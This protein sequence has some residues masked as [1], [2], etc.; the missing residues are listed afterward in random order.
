MSR[1]DKLSSRIRQSG[2]DTALPGRGVRNTWPFV[3]P[4]FRWRR[5][6]G[7]NSPVAEYDAASGRVG[8]FRGVCGLLARWPIAVEQPVL[9]NAY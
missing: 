3:S 4:R 9:Y 8:R 2:S 7:M 1:P 5:S 6:I